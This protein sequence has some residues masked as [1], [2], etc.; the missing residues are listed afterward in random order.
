MDT[1]MDGKSLSRHIEFLD[2]LARQLGVRPLSEYF[3]IA[4]EQAAE[5]MQG[6]G[7][8]EGDIKLPPLEQFSAQGGLDHGE[9]VVITP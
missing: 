3:S 4:P 1:D 2:A 7:I 9:S 6:E 8:E 5:L